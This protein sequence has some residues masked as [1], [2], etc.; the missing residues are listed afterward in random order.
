[1][2]G[3]KNTINKR[4]HQLSR[5]QRKTQLGYLPK[6]LL[7]ILLLVTSLQ[8]GGTAQ[9]TNR[10]PMAS[11]HKTL[12][13]KLNNNEKIWTHFKIHSVDYIKVKSYKVSSD[14]AEIQ[15]NSQNQEFPKKSRKETF[16]AVL[17]YRTDRN[18]HPQV[19][20]TSLKITLIRK[21]DFLLQRPEGVSLAFSA[22]NQSSR[23]KKFEFNSQNQPKIEFGE[24]ENLEIFELNKISFSNKNLFAVVGETQLHSINATRGALRILRFT[25]STEHNDQSF[26]SNKGPFEDA[27]IT[28]LDLLYT[29][30]EYTY[31]I[32]IRNNQWS[33]E[34]QV[35][36]S[37]EEILRLV[38]F[39]V[40][41]LGMGI[42]STVKILKIEPEHPRLKDLQVVDLNAGTTCSI[43][44]LTLSS[45]LP[46]I[47]P[48][49]ITETFALTNIFIIMFITLFIMHMISLV[50]I[51]SSY[52]H[53]KAR[54]KRRPHREKFTLNFTYFFIFCCFGGFC[55]LVG[56]YTHPIVC[57]LGGVYY[58]FIAGIEVGLN[59]N[60]YE[61]TRFLVG[62]L[63][64]H[65]L[66][67]LCFI[68][69]V[70][71]NFKENIELYY[72]SSSSW[73]FF[74]SIQYGYYL[75]LCLLLLGVLSCH[76]WYR[77]AGN[78]F[79]GDYFVKI[80]NKMSEK[81]NF[82]GSVGGDTN[83]EFQQQEFKF[84]K[85]SLFQRWFTSL[86]E[87]DFR[88]IDSENKNSTEGCSEKQARK[89]DFKKRNKRQRNKIEPKMTQNG[90]DSKRSLIYFGSCTESD[91]IRKVELLDQQE[92][93]IQ[94]QESNIDE[95][96]G[97][98]VHSLK[99]LQKRKNEPK[100]RNSDKNKE[101][102][103]QEQ[104]SLENS[105]KTHTL[106][107][108]TL[109]EDSEPLYQREKN[110]SN[111]LLTAG[112]YI[113]TKPKSYEGR[114]LKY[115]KPKKSPKT[116]QKY[117][118]SINYKYESLTRASGWMLDL[119]QTGARKAQSGGSKP[120]QRIGLVNKISIP[121]V[122]NNISGQYMGVLKVE[123]T[124][125]LVRLLNL[126]NRKIVLN[127]RSQETIQNREDRD[128]LRR[129]VY[130]EGKKT[131]GPLDKTPEVP[132][133]E[134]CLIISPI[135]D[136]G[137]IRLAGVSGFR[138][139]YSE[140]R[141]RKDQNFINS[142]HFSIF[143]L[144]FRKETNS[145]RLVELCKQQRTDRGEERIEEGDEIKLV[146]EPR[147]KLT[148]MSRTSYFGFFRY[149]KLDLAISDC[150]RRL[151][152]MGYTY[153]GSGS[154]WCLGTEKSLKNRN[155][156]ALKLGC[157]QI[158]KLH[159]NL[160]NLKKEIVKNRIKNGDEVRIGHN[161]DPEVEAGIDI[162]QPESGNSAGIEV[163]RCQ[164]HENFEEDNDLS[165]MATRT[166]DLSS[167][168]Q[169]FGFLGS[170]KIYLQ[171]DNN[172]AVIDLL[173]QRILQRLF[174]C[175]QKKKKIEIQAKAILHAFGTQKTKLKS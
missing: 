44:F 160:K 62:R 32:I 151:M 65:C 109:L 5:G 30:G 34:V 9:T 92:L 36:M 42:F 139:A 76:F 3:H 78:V 51:C 22:K 167:G 168:I 101:M 52:F 146:C 96:L 88:K 82:F 144:N 116:D 102:G 12:I 10:S 94:D 89:I 169:T 135:A 7:A 100:D 83:F 21:N 90:R 122:S 118:D 27:L 126:R 73:N 20:L 29:D 113:L 74:N 50:K 13:P 75:L 18:Q 104:T 164:F 115:S 55:W 85:P 128:E 134:A 59:W 19:N 152:L 93:Q 137:R 132:Y 147:F 103:T 48:F 170:G 145:K 107:T 98:T 91:K 56:S 125:V 63:V 58:L 155:S 99:K 87:E 121:T 1:M 28:N 120:N 159:Q 80:I 81:S 175:Q 15:E 165:S 162:N 171:Y 119:D 4:N 114:I 127:S 72:G 67:V 41:F 35:E 142:E 173:K 123:E 57:C 148:K 172:I 40:W 166:L 45:F 153:G 26:K 130:N 110:K 106:C 2:K 37:F 64:K 163:W 14:T 149:N 71:R 43:F 38:I 47:R 84:E 49:V 131:V 157:M 70:L 8:A 79:A 16:Q 129:S 156:R 11:R 24:I 68:Y 108:N 111:C 143:C 25:L 138:R 140:L 158:F 95:E 53:K 133:F 69:P 154:N 23:N 60:R 141:I 33:D 150:G 174:L 39:G 31:Q 6:R 161:I 124:R 86:S 112:L 136:L 105:N 66:V 54:E 46:M 117:K 97:K 61:K 17:H 77:L